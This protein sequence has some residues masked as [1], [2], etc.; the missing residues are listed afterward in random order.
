MARRAA[1]ARPPL[2]GPPGIGA[3]PAGPNPTGTLPFEPSPAPDVAAPP[4]PSARPAWRKTW[5]GRTAELAALA[6]ALVPA[7]GSPKPVAICALQ[8]M[9]GVGKTYLAERFAWEHAADFP[10]RVKRLALRPGE[11]PSAASLLGE[12][13]ALLEAPAAKPAELRARLLASRALV[14]VDNADDENAAEAAADL[15]R[16]LEGCPLIVTGRYGPLGGDGEWTVVRVAPFDEATALAQLAD[17][18][19]R[20]LRPT[21]RDA[22]ASLARELGYLPLALSLAGAHLRDGLSPDDFLARLREDHLDVALRNPA[23]GDP[24]PRRRH[25]GKTLA[26]SLDL[27]RRSLGERGP[28]LVTAFAAFA[29]APPAGVGASLAAAMTGLSRSDFLRVAMTATHLSVLDRAATDPPRWRLHP[30][31]AELVRQPVDAEPAFARM[32]DWFV[33]RLPEE[34]E[35]DSRPQGERWNEVHAETAALVDWL[36]RVPSDGMPRVVKSGSWYAM[37]CGP[38]ST[39]ASFCERVVRA[40]VDDST[41]SRGLTTLSFVHQKAGD[42]EAALQAADDKMAFARA[43]G[44]DFDLAVAAGLRADILQARGQLDEAL[45]IRK[46]DQLPVYE[47]L[48]DIRERAVTLG[49]IADVLQARGQLDEAV[50]IYRADVLPVYE[51]LGDRRM[52]LVDQTYLARYLLQRGQS[53]DRDEAQRLLRLALTAAQDMRLPEADQIREILTNAGFDA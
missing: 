8:G 51:R 19:G 6:R 38:F 2:G 29:H 32:T 28:D 39:W 49:K 34:S 46:E 53:T 20:P 4:P 31:V 7:R 17:E 44:N 10:G 43:I 11:V 23:K 18:L 27:L 47:K 26:L 30:L 21:K 22:F 50:R 12:L 40:Q 45:R 25:L 3:H 13:A 24:D 36:G 52:L 1:S 14:H 15:A 9:G 33:A 37:V 35:A 48:G 16:A 5:V 41:R 42:P